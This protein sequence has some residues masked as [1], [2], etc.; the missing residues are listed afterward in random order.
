MAQAINTTRGTC[1]LCGEAVSLELPDSRVP[2]KWRAALGHRDKWAAVSDEFRE[3][4]S[5]EGAAARLSIP[6]ETARL[7]LKFLCLEVCG[8][9]AVTCV[10]CLDDYRGAL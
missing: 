6:A 4:G 7:L 8:C 3:T 5:I 10:S 9:R 2:A 1:P